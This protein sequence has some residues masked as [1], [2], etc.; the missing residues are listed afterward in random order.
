[1]PQYRRP[2][3]TGATIFFDTALADLGA[4]LLARHVDLL[5]WAVRITRRERPFDIVA[6]TV[7]PARILCIWSL[8]AGDAAYPTRWRLIKT[9][10]SRGLRPGVRRESQCARQERGIW[11]RRYWEHHIRDAADL[12]DHLQLC[13]M[14]PVAAGLAARP[15]D[16]PLCSDHVRKVRAGTHLTASPD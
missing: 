8:P 16:W 7:L 12:S 6:C 14:A 15:G 10:F 2:R 3:A 4:D 11:A 9:R 1:M 5:R 13:R